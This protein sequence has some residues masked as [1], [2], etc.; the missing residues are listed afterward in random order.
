MKAEVRRRSAALER[1]RSTESELTDDMKAG[2]GAGSAV[3]MGLLSG[4][5]KYS[6][7]VDVQ[8]AKNQ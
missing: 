4:P 5:K 3:P 7:W 2:A 6:F 1:T 8:L